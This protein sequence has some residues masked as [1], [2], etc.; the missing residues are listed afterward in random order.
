MTVVNKTMVDK[1]VTESKI[2]EQYE[3][4]SPA[5]TLTVNYTDRAEPSPIEL[6]YSRNRAKLIVRPYK[7]LLN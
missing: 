4:K 7:L 1:D 5:L 6:I 2:E 3:S